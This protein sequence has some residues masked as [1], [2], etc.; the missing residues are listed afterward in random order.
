MKQINNVPGFFAVLKH[1]NYFL[2]YLTRLLVENVGG[3][4]RF[5]VSDKAG[6]FFKVNLV[7]RKSSPH[8]RVEVTDHLAFG[9]PAKYFQHVFCLIVIHPDQQ[10]GNVGRIQLIQRFPDKS[11]VTVL[12]RFFNVRYVFRVSSKAI[13]VALT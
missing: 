6:Y 1:G 7:A 8:V 3:V 5:D 2:P 11:I 13:T 4:I 12:Y 10:I 9:F